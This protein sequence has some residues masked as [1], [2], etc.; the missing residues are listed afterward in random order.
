MSTRIPATKLEV[1]PSFHTDL[2]Y[3]VAFSSQVHF[4]R[5]DAEFSLMLKFSKQTQAFSMAVALSVDR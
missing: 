5:S 1:P 4:A 3:L 2:L